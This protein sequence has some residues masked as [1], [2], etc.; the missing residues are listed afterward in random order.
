MDLLIQARQAHCAIGDS[1][2]EATTLLSL[3]ELHDD[4]GRAEDADRAWRDALAICENLGDPRAT[5]LRELLS[6]N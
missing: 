3:G 2:G 4:A 5:R 6:R 1:Y